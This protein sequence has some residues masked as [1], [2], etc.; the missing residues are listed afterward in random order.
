MLKDIWVNYSESLGQPGLEGGETILDNELPNVGRIVAE[1]K[2]RSS[3]PEVF[4]AVTVVIYD[5]FLNTSYF[6]NWQDAK[7]HI[8]STKL[9]IQSCIK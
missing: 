4:F 9:L 6:T 2:I 3:E 7:E 5:Q 1:K 8:D